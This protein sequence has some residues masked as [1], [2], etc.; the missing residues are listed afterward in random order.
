MLFSIP[1]TCEWHQQLVIYT[2]LKLREQEL[3]N[4]LQRTQTSTLSKMTVLLQ[5]CSCGSL[6]HR[7]SHWQTHVCQNSVQCPTSLCEQAAHIACCNPSNGCRLSR[8]MH[9]DKDKLRLLHQCP[10]Q[11]LNVHQTSSGQIFSKLNMPQAKLDVTHPYCR[12]NG[13]SQSLT[14]LEDVSV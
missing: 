12:S 8:A 3:S 14:E 6:G 11:I 10:C 2:C 9:L 1:E 13:P 7:R 4:I 5:Q